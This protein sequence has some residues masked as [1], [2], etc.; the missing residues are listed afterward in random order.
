[1]TRAQQS[2]A[3]ATLL[4]LG[5]LPFAIARYQISILTELLIFGLLAL[6]LDLI[7]GYTGMVSFGH[8]AYFGLGAYGS[9]LLLIHYA[10][11]VP[12]AMVGGAL[13]AGVI[14]LPVGYISTRATGIYFA[15]LTLAFAQLLYTIAYKWRDLTGGSDGIAGVPKTTLWWNGPSLASASAYYY[16]VAGSLVVSL[17]LCRALVRSPFGKALMAIRENERKFSVLGQDPRR[18]KLTVFVI[19]AV[20]AGLAG[21]L[22]APFRG[23]A[24]PE[25][26]FWVLSGQALMMVIIGGIGTL[27]GPVLGAM[28][29]MLIQEVLSSYTEQWMIFTGAIFVLMVIFLPGGVVGAVRSWIEGRSAAVPAREQG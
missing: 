14:A 8:A 27:I 22:F 21:S 1:V 17:F 10:V 15:M 16:L 25:V 12:V 18:F 3:V 19:A 28:L 13:L 2:L 23:F 29:F 11:P 24:S 5:V 4:V 6:S 7:M 26:M 9:A 20:F